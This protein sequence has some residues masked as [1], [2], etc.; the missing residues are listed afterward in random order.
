[1][2]GSAVRLRNRI[3]HHADGRR[4]GISRT[5]RCRI[6]RG[7]HQWRERLFLARCAKRHDIFQSHDEQSL[8]VERRAASE[9]L[10]QLRAEARMVV[11]VSEQHGALVHVHHFEREKHAILVVGIGVARVGKHVREA[12]G[13]RTARHTHQHVGPFG[14]LAPTAQSRFGATGQDRREARST[15]AELVQHHLRRTLLATIAQRT[16]ATLRG[17]AHARGRHPA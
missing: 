16:L 15:A 7:Q 8:L 1:L 12:T 5:S 3:G 13:C 6:R 11:R 2:Q 9:E 17:L 10:G 14:Q 4:S